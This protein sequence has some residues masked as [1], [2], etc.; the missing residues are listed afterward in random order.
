MKGGG[1]G[2][3]DKFEVSLFFYGDYRCTLVIVH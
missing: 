2:G 1:Q 3:R